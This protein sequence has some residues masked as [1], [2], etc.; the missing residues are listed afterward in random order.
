[1]ENEQQ[2]KAAENPV[3][4]K[5]KFDKDKRKR[6]GITMIIS[7]GVSLLLILFFIFFGANLLLKPE[8]RF[9]EDRSI[10]S[11]EKIESGKITIP[12]FDS[13]T[14]KAGETK[15]KA[16]IYNPEDNNCYFE[17]SI[18]LKNSEREIY[19][20]KLI[21]PGQNLYEIQ[22]NKAMSK[23]TYDAVL[24]YNT[25]TTDGS[26]TPLNGANIP[27]ELVVN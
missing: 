18:I 19:K 4:K 27:F 5:S 22:L 17:I 21:K 24:H 12:G 1:M 2:I 9:E 14:I 16:H 11:S 10:T 7:G 3:P 23:G 8:Y 25:Y 13:M 6:V 15:A 20:S 26:Y